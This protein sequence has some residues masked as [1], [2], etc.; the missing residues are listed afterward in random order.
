[1][2]TFNQS[3]NAIAG[4]IIVYV[5]IDCPR[6]HHSQRGGKTSKYFETTFR[7]TFDFCC[8]TVERSIPSVQ[9]ANESSASSYKEQELFLFLSNISHS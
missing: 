1:M 8:T 7:M 2:H 3:L 5:G 4:E 6:P 9:V